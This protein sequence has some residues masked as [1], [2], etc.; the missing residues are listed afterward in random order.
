MNPR[1]GPGVKLF[2]KDESMTQQH[3]KD[4]VDPKMIMEKYL[5]TGLV[6]PSVVRNAN[7]MIYGDASALPGSYEQALE[8]IRAAGEGFSSLPDRIKE[9]Y[10]NADS[11]VR[12]TADD[13][14]MSDLVDILRVEANERGASLAGKA[15]EAAAGT[16]SGVESG[17]KA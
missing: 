4:L 7:A 3:F 12:Q 6:D 10:G 1:V 13:R 8:V 14:G 17:A 11:F 16:P 5:K 15:D 2:C 9:R